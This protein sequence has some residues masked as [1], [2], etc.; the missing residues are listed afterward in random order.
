MTVFANLSSLSTVAD[1]DEFLVYDA[2]VGDFKRVRFDNIGGPIESGTWTPVVQGQTTA[3]NH[4]YA[5]Q[6]GGYQRIG[7][8]VHVSFRVLING[9]DWD[10][11]SAGDLAITGLPFPV[12]NTEGFSVASAG[13]CDQFAF[14]AGYTS[15]VFRAIK[16]EG[17][18]R[19]SRVAND[20]SSTAS[21]NVSERSGRVFLEASLSY[22]TT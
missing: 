17:I 21:V 2:S 13:A 10:I 22:R 15:P 9:G 12:S 5:S 8:I 19:L 3:G 16:G 11:N 18:V 14:P 7:N 6:A 20:G 4:T 1:A